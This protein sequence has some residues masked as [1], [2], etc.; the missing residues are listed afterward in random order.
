M[1][2]WCTG[3]VDKNGKEIYG[4]DIVIWWDG[5]YTIT[6]SDVEGTWILKDDRD[7][8]EC[9]SLYGISSPEQSRIEVIGNIYEN[10]E[11]APETKRP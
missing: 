1:P 9:P 4:G 2:M 3:K 11:F 5:Q 6:F 10:P 8:W 7:D